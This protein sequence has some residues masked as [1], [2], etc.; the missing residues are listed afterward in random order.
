MTIARSALFAALFTFCASAVAFAGANTGG[1]LV[2]HA[3]TELQASAGTS[4]C[5][6]SRVRDCLESRVTAPVEAR[7]TVVFLL[8]AFP[9][10]N[11]RLS[12]VSF[13]VYLDASI[14]I[15]GYGGCGD[16]ALDAEG[17]PQSGWG[18]AV[19]FNSA[20]TQ[21]ITEIYWFAAYAYS[22]GVFEVAD[23]PTQGAPMFADDA[24]PSQKDLVEGIGILGFGMAGEN[25][26]LESYAHGACCHSNGICTL[27]VESICEDASATYLGDGTECEP[28]TCWGACCHDDPVRCDQA[29]EPDCANDLRG[30]FKGPGTTCGNTACVPTRLTWGRLKSVFEE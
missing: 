27:E 26:C 4:P 14:S 19:T 10:S 2:L 21:R 22:E 12:G 7:E 30:E 8:A 20:R 15:F 18:S 28:E 24:V 6:Q 25:P 5:G 16:F 11:P 9:F 17:A 1:Y 29:S 23:H 3:A 13:G